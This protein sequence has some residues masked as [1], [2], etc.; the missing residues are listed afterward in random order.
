VLHGLEHRP[1]GVCPDQAWSTAMVVA[2]FVYGL[3]GVVPDAPHNRL[4]LAP[5]IP[6]E[7]PELDVERLRVGDGQVSLRYRRVGSLH[8]FR[9]AQT[10]G[11]VPLTLHFEPA[12]Q[13]RRLE[14]ARVDG[15]PA[16]LDAVRRGEGV[17]VPLQLVLDQERTVELEI[18]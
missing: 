12:I 13:G 15:R 16:E 18:A 11:A 9:I 7:W 1:A 5:Q 2:P 14:A 10:S 6:R 3:L 4:R 17:R 8:T